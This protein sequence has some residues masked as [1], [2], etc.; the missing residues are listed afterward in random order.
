MELWLSLQTTTNFFANPLSHIASLKAFVCAIYFASIVDKPQNNWRTVLQWISLP[1]LMW[2]RW[3]KQSNRRLKDVHA[4]ANT[5]NYRLGPLIFWP[6][7]HRFE[8]NGSPSKTQCFSMMLGLFSGIRDPIVSQKSSFYVL[9]I[10]E[11]L[12]IFLFSFILDSL[13]F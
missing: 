3:W 6:M 12:F 8:E 1:P 2:N 9:S 10:L 5:K 13:D 4:R 7:T 11:A